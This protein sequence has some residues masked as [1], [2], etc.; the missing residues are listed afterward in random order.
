MGDLSPVLGWLLV[1]LGM[2]CIA[3]GLVVINTGRRTHWQKELLQFRKAADRF[4]RYMEKAACRLDING[5]RTVMNW[6]SMPS[7]DE[8]TDPIAWRD[9]LGQLNEYEDKLCQVLDGIYGN[10]G[11]L[12]AGIL[13]DDEFNE[14]HEARMDLKE[15]TNIWSQRARPM[16]FLV[17]RGKPLHAAVLKALAYA[18]IVLAQ[19]LQSTGPNE[20]GL[21]KLAKKIGLMPSVPDNAALRDPSPS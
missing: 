5:W 14:F 1:F 20:I 19:R 4:M 21:W 16:S 17:T 13:E 18:E 8:T 10:E 7:I 2:V 15:I 11:P 6:V 3:S 9:Q 12:G